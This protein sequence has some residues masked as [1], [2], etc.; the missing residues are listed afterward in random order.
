MSCVSIGKFEMISW[1]LMPFVKRPHHTKFS[2][3]VN[4]ICHRCWRSSSFPHARTRAHTHAHTHTHTRTQAR[5]YTARTHART[6]VHTFAINLLLLNHNTGF[7]KTTDQIA[8]F[9]FRR[10]ANWRGNSGVYMAPTW[11]HPHRFTSI[12]QVWIKTEKS[13]RNAADRTKDLITLWLVKTFSYFP[14]LNTSVCLESRS[15]ITEINKFQL[16]KFCAM[17]DLK[18]L[19]ERSAYPV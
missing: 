16:H 3:S 6:H 8:V 7:S 11:S 2:L 14:S 12:S 13:T 1:K 9:H 18:H 10:L 15:Y 19:F 5:T 4:C 17:L